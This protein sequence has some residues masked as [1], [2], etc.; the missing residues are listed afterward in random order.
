MGIAETQKVTLKALG[1]IEA[2]EI[3]WEHPQMARNTG[4]LE[5]AATQT[6]SAYADSLKPAQAGLVCIAPDF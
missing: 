3:S 6:K 2:C 5:I 4:R 1:A